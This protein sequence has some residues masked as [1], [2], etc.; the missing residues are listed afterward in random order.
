[1]SADGPRSA[2]RS[3]STSSLPPPRDLPA[4]AAV[5][6]LARLEHAAELLAGNVGPELIVDVLLL[7][8]PAP[9]RAA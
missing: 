1:M 5:A 9:A 3:C 8:W 2:T 6:F 4:G 7:A